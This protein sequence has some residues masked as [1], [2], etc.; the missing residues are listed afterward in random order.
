[1][2]KSSNSSLQQRIL[3]EATVKLR[4]NDLSGKTTSQKNSVQANY[5]TTYGEEDGGANIVET[6]GKFTYYVRDATLSG[7]KIRV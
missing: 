6:K 3:D 1:M 7:E 2:S 5:L 4:N